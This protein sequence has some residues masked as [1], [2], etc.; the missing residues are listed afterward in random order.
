M[1]RGQAPCGELKEKIRG[2]SSAIDGP[3]SGQANC[4][5]NV[6]ILLPAPSF[7]S[8]SSTSTRPSASGH[9]GLD[10][11]GQSLAHVGAHDQA[12]D[13]DRDVV[14]VLLVEVELLLE[15]ADLAVHLDAREAFRA[16]LLEQLAVLALAPAHHRREHH[17]ARALLERHHVIDDLLGRL[18]GDRPPADVAVRLAHPRPQ[19]AQVV[20][21]LGHR[22][23]GRARVARG[24]LLV[25]R[26][27]RR[28]AL[29]RVDVGLVHLAEELARVRGQRLHVAALALGVDRVEGQRGLA[30]A[31]QAGDDHQGVARERDRD[32]PEV[33][34]PRARDGYAVVAC[35]RTV[36]L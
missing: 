6:R 14:L 24:R 9:R 15:L 36:R 17:E 35:H 25:D 23:D 13:D 20:V 7:S 31:R 26:D 2:S 21:D 12:V 29:D 3:C 1:Q 28:Q 5:E 34:L 30:R 27:G 22:A 19:Q 16:Q 8:T 33:V 4:S 10:R 11:V 18:P 32:V